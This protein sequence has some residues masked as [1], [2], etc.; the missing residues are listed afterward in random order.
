MKNH[1]VVVD[2]VET[3][4]YFISPKHTDF[5]LPHCVPITFY[6]PQNVGRHNEITLYT[7][8]DIIAFYYKEE[9][10]YKNITD[11]EDIQ[12]IL[13]SVSE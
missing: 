6:F 13:K 12:K 10:G 8:D 4:E 1:V 2:N 11:R 7:A 3:N 9:N 5:G